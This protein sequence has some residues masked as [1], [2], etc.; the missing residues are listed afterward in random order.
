MH[1][2]GPQGLSERQASSCL[3]IRLTDNTVC[4]IHHSDL[5]EHRIKYMQPFACKSQEGLHSR[6]PE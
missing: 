2:Q 1:A 3:N 5:E 6:G 4:T